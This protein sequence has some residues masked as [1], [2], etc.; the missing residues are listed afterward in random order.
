MTAKMCFNVREASEVSG[1]CRQKIYDA[2]NGRELRGFKIGRRTVILSEDLSD[3][4]KSRE[5]YVGEGM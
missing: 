4:I 5:P 1:I 3:W 2:L